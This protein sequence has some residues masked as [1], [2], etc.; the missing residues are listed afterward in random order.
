[1][2]E[3]FDDQE[4]VDLMWHII[5][6]VVRSNVGWG[7]TAWFYSSSG[8]SGKARFW[9]CFGLWSAGKTVFLSDWRIVTKILPWSRSCGRPAF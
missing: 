6:A 8:N 4:L 2:R 5:G 3:L 9:H 1:M 7:R